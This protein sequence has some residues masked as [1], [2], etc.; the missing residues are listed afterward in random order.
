MRGSLGIICGA[1]ALRRQPFA[2][3]GHVV[4]SFFACHFGQNDCAGRGKMAAPISEY[5]L[6]R[7]YLGNEQNSYN[8]LDIPQA[9]TYISLLPILFMRWMESGLSH[10]TPEENVPN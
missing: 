7:I 4:F 3:V 2:L 9:A 6:N 8:L 1:F 5:A 10:N